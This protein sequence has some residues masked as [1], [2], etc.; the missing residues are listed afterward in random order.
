MIISK[1]IPIVAYVAY[2]PFGIEYL[3]R[4]V[5]SYTKFKSGCKHK[6]LICFKGFSNTYELEEWKKIIN[7]DFIELFEK[8]EKNDFDIGSY[9]RIAEAY[10]DNL[11]L[12]LDTHTRMNC[13][14][15]L[16]IFLDNYRSKRLI[17]A[18][19]SFASISS[20]FL[21]FYYTQYS[22]FQQLRWGLYHWR[23]F[24]L[25][26]NPHIRTTGFFLRGLDLLNLDFDRNKFDKKIETNYFESGRKNITLQLKKQGYEVGLV[27]SDN[28][29]FETSQWKN[30]NTYCL[31][32]QKKLIFIDNRTEEYNLSDNKKK[33][34]MTKFC[35]GIS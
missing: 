3:K 19:G 2:G 32:A 34:K 35:W 15:W 6:L 23:R 1:E 4:F 11:I 21:G 27:N 9:F 8:N 14:N 28:I 17:G 31:N 5:S 30:S 7:H 25:F 20:Q 33:K 10:K 22:K 16:K 29:F 18:T 12:F 26:P 24:K 13:D